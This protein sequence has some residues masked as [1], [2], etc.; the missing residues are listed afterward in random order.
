MA[1]NFSGGVN[2]ETGDFARLREGNGSEP[3]CLRPHLG[4]HYFELENPD[5]S[6]FGEKILDVSDA[7]SGTML[8]QTA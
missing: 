8:T 6:A 2:G 4:L 1:V 3:A 5:D 7:Q